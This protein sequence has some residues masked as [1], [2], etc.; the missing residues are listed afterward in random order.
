MAVYARLVSKSAAYAGVITASFY[1]GSVGMRLVNGV[2]VQRYGARRLML[3]S[4]A[5]C[6]AACLAHSFAAGIA[7]LVLIRVLHGAGYSVFSTAS[8]TAASYMVP[9]SRLGEGMGYFTIGNVLAMAVGPSVALSIVAGGTQARFKLLFCTAAFVCA[10]AFVLVLS[11]RH[12]RSAHSFTAPGT[13]AVRPPK[14]FLG[15]ERGV[16]LPALISFLMTFAYSPAIVYL[17]VYGLSKG[18]ANVGFAFTMYAVGLLSSRLFTGRLSDRLGH[19]CVMIPA[20]FCG[21]AA[22]CLLAFC[23]ARWQLEAAMVVMGLCVGAYNPQINVL[24]ISRCSEARRGTATAAFNGASDL[25]LAMG[26]A[27]TGLLIERCGYRFT[28]LNGAFICFLTMFVYLFFLSEHAGGRHPKTS[29][30][31]QPGGAKSSN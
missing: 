8:G 13:A 4:A 24:C 2:M 31:L 12:G 16:A 11:I 14:T 25:G 29:A 3:L 19:D 6:A 10:A 27:L 17:S 30:A 23:A 1:I 5:L 18:W 26:S 15:F 21:C 28:F 20:Y 7:L 9:Q 22:L